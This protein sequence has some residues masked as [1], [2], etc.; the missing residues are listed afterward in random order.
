MYKLFAFDVNTRCRYIIK[1][2]RLKP[3]FCAVVQLPILV[4]SAFSTLTHSQ[5]TPYIYTQNPLLSLTSHFVTLNSTHVL[6]LHWEAVSLQ[7]CL[8]HLFLLIYSV[9]QSRTC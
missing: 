7:L 2:D 3:T 8:M 5:K 4:Y 6:F 1:I 9:S